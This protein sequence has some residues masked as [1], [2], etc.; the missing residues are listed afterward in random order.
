MWTAMVTGRNISRLPRWV[1][2][3]LCF[4]IAVCYPV[5]G[6]FALEPLQLCYFQSEVSGGKH[7]RVLSPLALLSK[8]IMNDLFG[9]ED[10]GIGYYCDLS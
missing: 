3:D 8:K 4:A 9:K 5:P 10:R 2:E 6:A 7:G 1:L